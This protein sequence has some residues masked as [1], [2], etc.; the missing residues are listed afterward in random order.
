MKIISIFSA[1]LLFLTPY[2]AR[3]EDLNEIFK[4]VNEFVAA[5]NYSKAIEELAWAKKE[6]EKLNAGQINTF[7]PDTLGEFKGGEI[8]QGAAL[9]IMNTSRTYTKASAGLGEYGQ[10][11]VIISL[12]GGAGGGSGSEG[13]GGLM[14]LG[15]MAAMMDGGQNTFRINGKTANLTEMG[16][17]A[18]LTVF[19]DSGSVLKLE[20]QNGVNGAQLKSMAESLKLVELDRYL[21]G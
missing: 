7:F 9:G 12:T 8:E 21:K 13:L 16:D 4:R 15:K 11:T 14:A 1:C 6:I 17:G 20:G 3:A 5:K 18:S 10:P 19:L 2:I